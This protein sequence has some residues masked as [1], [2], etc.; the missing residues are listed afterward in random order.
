[1]RPEP[2]EASLVYKRLR[3]EPLILVFPRGHRLAARKSIRLSEIRGEP[4]IKPAK[5]APALRTIVEES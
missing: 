4:L 1:M 2:H 3:T 5:T